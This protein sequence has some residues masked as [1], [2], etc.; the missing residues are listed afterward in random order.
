MAT[1][2]EL[3]QLFNDN[4]LRNK[5]EVACIVA[6]ETIRVE[7]PEATT[8]HANRLI[9]AK[10]VFTSPHAASEQMQMA[11]LASN[12]DAVVGTI[13]GVSDADLQTLVD[14]AVNM[15]ADGS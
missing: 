14:A 2:A 4:D 7:D 13:T 10:A 15:F 11:L 12:K 9:W 1:Y 8:N 6:A 3:R 5:I